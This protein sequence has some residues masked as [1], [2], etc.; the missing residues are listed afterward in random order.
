MKYEKPTITDF[1]S[2]AGHT[3]PPQT[4]VVLSPFTVQRRPDLWP[5]PLRFDPD[6]FLPEHDAERPRGSFIAFSDGP[7][8]CIGAYFA[9]IEAPLVLAT[10]LQRVDFALTSGAEILPESTA[11]LRP[12]GGVPLRVTRRPAL[13]TSDPTS[14]PAATAH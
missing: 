12:R 9:L 13:A 2:I 7:R 10:M 5:D 6:R 14:A 8:V 4:I 1:G 11:T 3:L